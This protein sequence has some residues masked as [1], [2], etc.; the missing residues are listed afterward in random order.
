MDLKIEVDC[1]FA[2]PISNLPPDSI[3]QSYLVLKG[4]VF[5]LAQNSAQLMCFNQTLTFGKRGYLLKRTYLMEAFS[6]IP[7]FN[8]EKERQTGSYS[9]VLSKRHHD[10]R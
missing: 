2:S 3:R 7:D 1:V 6:N 4:F 8:N 9:Q 10:H 5:Y